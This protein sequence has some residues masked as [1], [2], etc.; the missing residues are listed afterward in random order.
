[1]TTNPDSDFRQCE[2]C[3]GHYIPITDPNLLDYYVHLHLE[4]EEVIDQ[5]TVP[6]LHAY[7]VAVIGE[8]WPDQLLLKYGAD[9]IRQTLRA[10]TVSEGLAFQKGGIRIPRAYLRWLLKSAPPQASPQ[11]RTR[12][13]MRRA[14]RGG[15]GRGRSV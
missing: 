11:W 2:V 12:S 10:A 9:Y 8:R 15:E 4:P 3:R 13:K 5:L 1:M 14:S 7:L 6:A